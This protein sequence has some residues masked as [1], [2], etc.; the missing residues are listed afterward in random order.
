MESFIGLMLV[1]V[2]DV[3]FYSLMNVL[4]VWGFFEYFLDIQ[5]YFF[6]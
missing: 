6:S 1:L 4:K 3:V 2:L 5:Y